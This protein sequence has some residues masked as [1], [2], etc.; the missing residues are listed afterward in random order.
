MNPVDE[1]KK[2]LEESGFGGVEPSLDGGYQRWGEKKSLWLWSLEEGGV[3]RAAWA[4]HREGEIHQWCSE[5]ELSDE[6]R[7]AFDEKLGELD[8]AKQEGWENA[9]AT[10]QTSWATF[11]AV[12]N[13]PY[14]QRKGLKDNYGCKMGESTT[15]IPLRDI[16]GQ[17]WSLQWIEPDGTKGF[18]SGG[19]VAGCFHTIGQKLSEADEIY[20]C[21]GVATGASIYEAMG[22][23]VVCAMNAGNMARVAKDLK[24]KYGARIVVC[25]DSDEVGERKGKEAAG[26]CGARLAVPK[27]LMSGTDW[28]DLHASAGVDAVKQQ[29]EVVRAQGKKLYAI[30]GGVNKQNVPKAPLEAKVVDT[31]LQYYGD[32]VCAQ[33]GVL[34]LYNGVHWEEATVDHVAG[35]KQNLRILYG[36]GFADIRRM[37]AAYKHFLMMVPKV[38]CE[39]TPDG[40][41][42]IDLFRVNPMAVNFEN[43]SLWCI[44]QKDRT[45]KLIFRAGHRPDDWLTTLL[46]YTYDEKDITENSEFMQ[47]LDRV[48]LDDPDKEEK[49]RALAQMYG[50]CLLPAFPRLFFLYGKSGTGKSTAINLAT[51]L[52]SPVNTC[53]VEPHHFEG[54]GKESMINK[55]INCVT[56]VTL[57]KPMDDAVLKRIIDQRPDTIR[58][59]GIKDI[60]GYLPPVHIFG[61]NGIPKTLD[62][63]SGAHERRWTF[64]EFRRVQYKEGKSDQN[65]WDSVYEK[66]PRGILNF[67]LRG[68]RDLCESKGHWVQPQSGKEKMKKWEDADQVGEFLSEIRDDDGLKIVG[69]NC[70]LKGCDG[71]RYVPKMRLYEAYKEWHK[72]AGGA[73]HLLGRNTFFDKV[74]QRGLVGYRPKG[75]VRCYKG[76]FIEAGKSAK[77]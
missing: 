14:L 16:D 39:Y 62:G 59:K 70:L 51:K 37:D 47:M 8:R 40:Q 49:I 12:A 7:A 61:G 11:D 35:V 58:R 30:D 21:E 54:F 64:I 36:Y 75:G 15:W 44:K 34:F 1:L 73:V 48:F 22:G 13:S 74:E 25:A 28:N 71:E 33:D 29:I 38:P 69:G 65:Y 19:R 9:A 17:L 6:Q 5:G 32:W 42:K 76:V 68:L 55:L 27:G 53:G 63:A 31:L 77:E 2:K 41:R 46:P 67:A 43:G 56:D 26:A 52:V 24:E 23:T 72:E 50:A 3:V 18:M 57:H 20:I 4:D 45:F 10:A 60:Q 66:S